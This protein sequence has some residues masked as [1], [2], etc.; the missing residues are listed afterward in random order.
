MEQRMASGAMQ[1]HFMFSSNFHSASGTVY[2]YLECDSKAGYTY[3]DEVVAD[4]F[5][6]T[7]MQCD[8]RE[9]QDFAVILNA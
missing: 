3:K 9:F 7:D 5:A 4:A 2:P 1:N 8:I 6:K